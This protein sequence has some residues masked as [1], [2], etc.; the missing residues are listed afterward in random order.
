MSNLVHHK[1]QT[2]KNTW[3]PNG[4]Q[5]CQCGCLGFNN[6]KWRRSAPRGDSRIKKTGML[7]VSLKGW[8]KSWSMVLL[9]IF[10]LKLPKQAQATPRL[11]LAWIKFKISNK[12]PHRFHGRVPPGPFRYKETLEG[13]QR[14]QQ[15]ATSP[16]KNGGL[17]FNN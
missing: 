17:Q 4:S 15:L 11:V 9:R 1:H 2:N 16:A 6:I 13:C 12:H 7:V 14:C 8:C 3:V 5:T 10:K